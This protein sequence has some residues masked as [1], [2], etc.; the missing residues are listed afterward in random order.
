MLWALPAFGIYL[1]AGMGVALMLGMIAARFRDVSTLIGAC[2]RLI[3]FFTPVIWAADSSRAQA[4]GFMGLL[5]RWNP[6]SYVLNTLRDGLV[7]LPPDPLNW[8]VTGS[9][10]LLLLVAGIITLERMGRRVTYWL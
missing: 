6:F 3:F 10:A 1:V 4:E 8:I 5:V 2:M 7:G 9:I